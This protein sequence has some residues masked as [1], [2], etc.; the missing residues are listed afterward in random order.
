VFAPFFVVGWATS[1]ANNPHYTAPDNEWTKWAHDNALKG[2]ISAFAMLVAAFVF[3][4]FIAGIR[5]VL[6]RSESMARDTVDFARVAFAGGVTGIAGT[7]MAFVSIANASSEGDSANAVVSRAVTTGSAGPF[8]VGAMGF[9][10]FLIAVGVLTLRGGVLARWTGFVA[11]VGGV[12]FL[13]TFLT[14]LNNTGNGSAFGYAFFP[15]LLSLVTWTIATSLALY[16]V[17]P[18]PVP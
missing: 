12:C 7:T 10:A 5:G 17:M 4:Y 2:R 15:A 1:V 16:R 18:T 11:I 13:I 3:L 6:G 9:A 8:L 14:T